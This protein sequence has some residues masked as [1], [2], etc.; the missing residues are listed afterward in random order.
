MGGEINLSD[1]DTKS[2]SGDNKKEE[3]KRKEAK[4]LLN[5][6]MNGY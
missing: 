2:N 5:T 1:D 6:N 3:I 4:S